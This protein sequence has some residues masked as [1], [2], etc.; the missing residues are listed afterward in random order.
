MQVRVFEAEDMQ[1]A[2][3]RIKQELGSKAIIISTRTVRKGK[4]GVFQKPK[5]EV[6][7]ALESENGTESPEPKAQF[8]AP[9]SQAEASKPQ[10]IYSRPQLNPSAEKQGGKTSG[11]G[12]RLEK[13]RNLEQDHKP[14]EG[15]LESI[16][17][18]IA[19]L[20]Q[21][22]K[23]LRATEVRV[24]RSSPV[25]GTGDLQGK[26]QVEDEV[27]KILMSRE[28]EW[29]A[30]CKIAARFKERFGQLHSSEGS[31]LLEG[32]NSVMAELIKVRDPLWGEQGSRKKR[33]ALLGPTG[34]G[35]TTTVA[36][37]AAN[38]LSRISPRIALIT[39]DNYRIAA[40]EQLKIYAQIMDLSLEVVTDPKQIHST[41]A[42]HEDKD[43]ILVDTAGRSPKDE[44]S[45]QELSSFLTPE[46]DVENHLLLAASTREQDM[47][48]SIQSF[49]RFGLSGLVF[50]KMDE[51]EDYRALFNIQ[52]RNEFPLSYFTTGQKVPE[53]LM[54]AKGSCIAEGIIN[55][56]RE[57]SHESQD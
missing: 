39:V 17:G 3:S 14:H 37:L 43:L 25:G 51:C 30:A 41:L 23:G 56:T 9:A 55:Q 5:L 19:E 57:S 50:T 15:T 13:E 24:D 44:A 45:L 42:R 8:S 34:V 48:R 22:V 18:E 7:A 12:Q 49:Q 47:Q 21:M 53:D 20:R 2:L 54:A 26:T 4:T 1:S 11:S 33:M 28:I 38:Y 29:E 35:K 40:V 6:T 27:L 31:P 16:Q 10:T 36:K 46:T 52:F 32:I